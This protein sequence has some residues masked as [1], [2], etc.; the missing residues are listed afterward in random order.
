M[1]QKPSMTWKVGAAVLLSM[2]AIVAVLVCAAFVF[3]D[4]P[5][6]IGLPILAI[7]G[8]VLLLGTL[9]IVAI[10]FS[11]FGIDD[12]KQALGLPDGSIRAAIA[13]SLIVLFGIFAVYFYSSLSDS[14]FDQVAS[15]DGLSTESANAIKAN[16]D[17]RVLGD[18]VTKVPNGTKLVD[19]HKIF[20]TRGGP[21]A[22]SID[23]AKQLMT[24]M[25]TLVTAIA[26]FYFG[27]KAA[28]PPTAPANPDSDNPPTPL[29]LSP[30]T[31]PADGKPPSFILTGTNLGGVSKVTMKSAA[32]VPIVATS[33]TATPTAVTFSAVIPANVPPQLW[34]VIALVKGVEYTLHG[35]YKA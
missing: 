4:M 12:P 28:A 2:A 32:G 14:S 26:S 24:L 33:V 16:L 18:R 21:D 17:G 6:E 10:T 20:F 9:A 7:T 27:S 30:A 31:P 22:A 11:L 19:S 1:G 15:I 8:I 5:R 34:D 35:A 29:S 23:F 3:R 13:L 25:G